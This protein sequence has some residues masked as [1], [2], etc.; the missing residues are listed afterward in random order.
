MSKSIIFA[1]GEGLDGIRRTLFLAGFL[2]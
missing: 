1:D 2:R